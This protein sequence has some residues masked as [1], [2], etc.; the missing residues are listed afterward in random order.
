MYNLLQNIFIILCT[1][2]FSLSFI[3]RSLPY[4][5]IQYLNGRKNVYL[6]IITIGLPF[7][8]NLCLQFLDSNNKKIIPENIYELLQPVAL[9]HWI[10]GD[11]ESRDYGLRLCTD[12][13]S[14]KEV[15]ILM[16]VLNIRYDINCKLYMTKIATGLKPRIVIPSSVFWNEKNKKKNSSSLFYTWNVVQIELVNISNKFKI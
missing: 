10:M 2:I 13:Y 12:S 5:R 8:H 4:L 14:I 6:S 11:G 1:F 3:F 7:I 9:A 15:I 16:N